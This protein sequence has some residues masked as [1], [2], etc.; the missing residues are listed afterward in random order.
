MQNPNNVESIDKNKSTGPKTDA[1][2]LRS[3]R[4]AEKHGV[5]SQQ[6]LLPGESMEQF[7][8]LHDTYKNDHQPRTSTEESLVHRLAMITWKLRR[9]DNLEGLAMEKAAE[10]GDLDGKFLNN[11]GLYAQRMHSIFEK[12]LKLL[13]AEQ[14]PRLE[15]EGENWRAAVLLHD[16]YKRANIPWD[17]ASDEFVFSRE[18]LDKQL[19]FNQRWHNFMKN[20]HIYAT[21]KLQDMRYSKEVL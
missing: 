5:F 4:N 6:A 2:K 12:T 7:E 9:L 1:G 20:P 13:H 17:P 8:A 11:Y 18:L 15:A 3:S 21:T 10:S 14:H 16:F 19:L